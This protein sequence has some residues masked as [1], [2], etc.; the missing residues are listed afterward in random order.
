MVSN[1]SVIRSFLGIFKI[2]GL[3]VEVIIHN[4]VDPLRVTIENKSINSWSEKRKLEDLPGKYKYVCAYQYP[5]TS[6]RRVFL[7]DLA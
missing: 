7:Q 1:D 6:R 3:Q 2:L 5:D 4:G